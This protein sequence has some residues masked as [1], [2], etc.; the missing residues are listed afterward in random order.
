MEPGRILCIDGLYQ[1]YESGFAG[2]DFMRGDE[3][4][5]TRFATHSRRVFRMRAVAPTMMPRL[6][7][8]VWA[9]GFEVKQWMRKR[10]GRSL[11]E[12]KDPR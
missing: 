3:P 1:L 8:A 10:T 6:R 7:H 2:L 9:T 12:V 5:K 4:Y 11:I